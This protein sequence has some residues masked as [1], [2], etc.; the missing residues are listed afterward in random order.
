MLADAPAR[1]LNSP[2]SERIFAKLRSPLV[3]WP[4]H[5]TP[6][7]TTAWFLLLPPAA[8]PPPSSLVPRSRVP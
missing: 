2:S 3:A 1:I 6:T 5:P 7:S 8:I 4:A